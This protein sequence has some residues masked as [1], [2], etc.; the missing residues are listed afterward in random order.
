MR[1]NNLWCEVLAS[2]EAVIGLHEK[3]GFTREA[4]YRDHVMKHGAYQDVIGLAMR[5]DDWKHCAPR[6][7]A[8]LIE[9]GFAF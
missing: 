2:N 3:V 7:R 5:A 8:K 9:K 4:H 1:L 6:L